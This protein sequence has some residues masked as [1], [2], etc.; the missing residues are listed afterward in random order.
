MRY[1]FL[2]A[3]YT[4]N[5]LQADQI[6]K[7]ELT[8]QSEYYIDAIG[9]SESN[10]A[11]SK[12]TGD[13]SLFYKNKKQKLYI[14]VN[15]HP[16][17]GQASIEVNIKLEDTKDSITK[18]FPP[19]RI[20]GELSISIQIDE[21]KKLKISCAQTPQINPIQEQTIQ[22]FNL[23]N[24][25]FISLN[26]NT[27]CN[28]KK[29][30]IKYNE[31]TKNLEVKKYYKIGMNTEFFSLNSPNRAE[32]EKQKSYFENNFSPLSIK[33]LAKKKKIN[34]VGERRQIKSQEL[35]LHDIYDQENYFIKGYDV[36]ELKYVLNK[37]VNKNKKCLFRRFK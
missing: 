3:F 23:F 18:N 30:I 7:F 12:L 26:N 28:E 9:I 17:P 32:D 36:L 8:G 37:L 24:G 20:E 11:S 6:C 29:L 1:F 25:E 2:I 33:Q 21:Y 15:H 10:D 35:T 34:S 16:N 31:K 5:Y 22:D 4:L 27:N 19:I 13:S 14:S